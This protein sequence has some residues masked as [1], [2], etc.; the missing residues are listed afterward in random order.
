[1]VG[2]MRVCERDREKIKKE[3]ETEYDKKKPGT[4]INTVD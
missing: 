1:M 4:G 2:C 3:G